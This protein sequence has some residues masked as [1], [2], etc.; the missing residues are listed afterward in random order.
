MHTFARARR[1]AS[2]RPA[3]RFLRHCALALFLAPLLSACWHDADRDETARGSGTFV[4]LGTLP[5]SLGSEATAVSADGRV[6]TGAS[7]SRAGLR[8]AFRWTAQQGVAS[9]GLLPGGSF[10]HATAISGDGGV[11]VGEADGGGPGLHAFRWTVDTTLSQVEGLRGSSTCASGGVSVDG[12]VVVGTCLAPMS[13]AF[14]WT[15]ASGVVGLGRFGTGSNATSTASAVSGNGEIT[16]GAGHPALTGAVLWDA[17]GAPTIIGGLPGDTNGTVTALSRDGKVAAGVSVDA[18]GHA[19][20]FRWTGLS[21]VMPLG[22]RD[23]FTA[24]VASS[25]SADGSRIVGWAGKPSG[26]DVAVMWDQT[27]A[28]RAVFDLLSSEGRRASAGWTLTRARGISTDGR[29]IVGE[30]INAAGAAEGWM[31]LLHE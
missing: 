12:S 21:G 17:N 22:T 23:A 8:T 1:T 26:P 4:A 7:T 24:T 15:A 31:V 20:A 27:G 5:G 9:L 29:V 16:G 11:I 28:W 2:A 18:A 6:V 19:R 13:E 25:M 14:R 3:R 10:S 30:A